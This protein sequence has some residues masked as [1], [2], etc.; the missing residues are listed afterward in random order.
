YGRSEHMKHHA[1][2]RS[3]M[4]I[5]AA[6]TAT[7]CASDGGSASRSITRDSAGVTIV[8]STSAAW[9]AAEAWTISGDPLLDIGVVDGP[10]EYQ[11]YRASSAVRLSDGRV[12]IANGGTN[13]LRFYDPEGRHLASIGRSGEGPGE[14][15]DLQR[16]WI[17]PGDS[18]LA[19]DF[20][21]SRLSVFSPD[22]EFVR[23]Q[24]YSSP[25]GRQI[26]IRG[27]LAD[28][29]IIA[30]GVPI[31]SSPGAASGV[32]RDSVPYY[33]YDPLG[34]VP[35]TFGRFPSA[36]VFRIVTGDDWQ[37][38]G[39]PFARVPVTAVAGNAVHFGSASTY[40]LYTYSA[41]GELERVVRLSMQPRAVTAADIDQYRRERLELAERE[42]MRPSMERMLSVLPFPGTMP[43]YDRAI[44]DSEGNVW[45]S[46]YRPARHEPATWRVFS[47]DG[48][49]L[50]SIDAPAQFEV[51]QI[52]TDFILAHWSDEM[53]V[54]HIRV[55][56]LNKPQEN[57]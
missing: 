31:W 13:E 51:I 22:G 54:E 35:H 25:D 46:D 26:L 45:L 14:F 53:D 30:A 36:E 32:V 9:N 18:L 10:A 43:P 27:P 15:Q 6:V 56:A 23:S 48:V 20:L 16:V 1:P 11:L 41:N 44:A 34:T 37:L 8:E 17:L 7:A 28:G 40:E 5:L 24:H 57:A 4:L 52:G 49:F 29:S 2:C 39:V 47:P 38:T 50:G 42:G 12:V 55:Y 3:V 21:P 19:Y 33:R